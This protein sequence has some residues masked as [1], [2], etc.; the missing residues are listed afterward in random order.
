MSHILHALLGT[1]GKRQG[2]REGRLLKEA[3][4]EHQ[5]KQLLVVEV[6]VVVK[7]SR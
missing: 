3:L 2:G 6:E 5:L 1:G 7:Q 4:V